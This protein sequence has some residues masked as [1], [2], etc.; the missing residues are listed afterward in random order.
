MIARGMGRA[1]PP[2]GEQ[3]PRVDAGIQVDERGRSPVSRDLKFRIRRAS[4][5]LQLEDGFRDICPVFVPLQRRRRVGPRVR[6]GRGAWRPRQR[7][8][9]RPMQ[10][11]SR[12]RSAPISY[13]QER[14]QSDDRNRRKDYPGLKGRT[15]RGHRGYA[16]ALPSSTGSSPNTAAPD[17]RPKRNHAPGAG[18]GR[19]R[20][21]YRAPTPPP[22]DIRSRSPGPPASPGRCPNSRVR[23]SRP[24]LTAW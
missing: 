9:P 12:S 22:P 3:K 11:A 1:G 18:A 7:L 2:K 4:E 20:C 10:S 23:G 13:G 24:A 21:S 17:K 16:R 19:S 5:R 14:E 15:S 8:R 6:C